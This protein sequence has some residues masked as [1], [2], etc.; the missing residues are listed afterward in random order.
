MA[1]AVWTVEGP[2]SAACSSRRTADGYSARTRGPDRGSILDGR[3]MSN[4]VGT[5][6]DPIVSLRRRIRLEPGAT[7]RVTF[8][9]AAGWTR[10]EVLKLADKYRDPASFE[11]TTTLAWTQA[12]VQLR[13]LNIDADEAHL[14]Q[15]VATRVIY[16]DPSLRASPEILQ[17]NRLGKSA[18]WK[19]GISGDLP[20]VLV[21]ID[22][23]DDREIVRQLMR[24]HEYWRMRG[25]RWIS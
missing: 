8:V 25:S 11:R 19:H 10:E 21:R 9:T 15:R 6:L 3:P 24:A 12:Q 14:F 5:V 4:T 17:R 20:I 16:S 23:S 7:G 13:H 22:F 2:T 18:L 1:G